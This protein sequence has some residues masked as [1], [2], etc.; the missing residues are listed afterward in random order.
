MSQNYVSGPCFVFVG[1]GT[2]GALTFLGLSERGVDVQLAASYED[3]ICDASGPR[4]P[5]DAQFMGEQ[6]FISMTLNRYNELVL[7]ACAAR[8]GPNGGSG[9]PDPNVAGEITQ[10]LLGSL[11]IAEGF[12]Y[13]LFLYA[14]YGTKSFQSA[15][16]VK[17]YTFGAAWLH[18]Q[19]TVPMSVVVKQPR[20]VFRAIPVWNT[21]D[22]TA[23]LY[24]NALPSP[25][26]TNN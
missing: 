6:A 2:S 8:T 9:N 11:M 18:D 15:T 14:P 7:Q 25:L 1:T 24:T 16:I 22:L 26:P 13:S 3:V 10:N 5:V 19:F 21:V 20:V 17:G 4:V 23:L 12:A